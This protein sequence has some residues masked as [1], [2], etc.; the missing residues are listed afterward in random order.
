MMVAKDLSNAH[1]H[2]SLVLFLLYFITNRSFQSALPVFD[3]GLVIF[4][5]LLG[6]GARQYHSHQ[7]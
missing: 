5:L 7:F 2:L 3:L 4:V 6:M 1:S